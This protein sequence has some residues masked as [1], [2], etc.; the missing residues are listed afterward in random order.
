M[1][2]LKRYVI[3]TKSGKILRLKYELSA[4]IEEYYE[5]GIEEDELIKNA[6][7]KIIFYLTDS[8]ENT[9]IWTTRHKHICEKIIENRFDFNYNYSHDNHNS[10][11]KPFLELTM[12]ELTKEHYK[13]IEIEVSKVI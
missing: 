12:E 9:Q 10:I 4:D 7:P 6:I 8:T 2:T 3:Q 11:N 13:V 5:Q 1:K